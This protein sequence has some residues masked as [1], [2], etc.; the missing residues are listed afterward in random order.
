MV[1]KSGLR[2]IDAL[3]PQRCILCQFPSRRS[4]A[5]CLD[6]EAELLANDN[7][8]HRCALP[9]AGP[10]TDEK[11]RL[12][13]KCLQ[14]PP[15]YDRVI[16]PFLYD[17]IFS[18]LIHRWKFQREQRLTSLLAHLWLAGNTHVPQV[19]KL[20]PVPLH[21]RRRWWRG[22]NQ[23]ELLCRELARRHPALA[24]TA[25]DSKLLARSRPTAPQSGMNLRQRAVN[26]EGAFTVRGPCDNL[27]LAVVDDVLT[28]GA[29][30]GAVASS[31]RAAGAA[32]VEI[33]CLARTPPPG[34][35][36]P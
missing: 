36:Q 19:D 9:L 11:D 20:V 27:R 4:Q 34:R 35:S 13:A 33:W 25:C 31:L 24:G 6:C 26:L 5:L 8:C 2:L 1:N 30:A 16:A 12:C 17:E 7:A 32:H 10:V 29:T 3:F 22:F 18:W 15:P 14:A 21:W 28:T 23:S